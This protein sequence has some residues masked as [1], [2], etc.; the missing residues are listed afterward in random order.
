MADYQPMN[1]VL[2]VAAIRHRLQQFVQ[3][4]TRASLP[5]IVVISIAVLLDKWGWFRGVEFPTLLYVAVAAV[6]GRGLWAAS[7]RVSPVELLMAVD[8]SHGLPDSLSSAWDFMQRSPAERTPQMEAHLEKALPEFGNVR[9]SR[10]LPFTMPAEFPIAVVLAVVLAAVGLVRPPDYP[11]LPPVVV[12]SPPVQVIVDTGRLLEDM[13]NIETLSELARQSD[14]PAI[15]AISEQ[16]EG[17]TDQLLAG[18]ISADDL[19]DELDAIEDDL[20][21]LAVPDE[22]VDLGEVWEEVA[23]E[24]DEVMDDLGIEEGSA[25]RQQADDLAEAIENGDEEAISDALDQLAALLEE[26]E[27][28]PEDA[29]ALADMLE[30]LADVIDPADFDLSAQMAELED[31]IIELEERVQRRGRS[32]DQNR[33]DDA[34]EALDALQERMAEERQNQ[35][36]QGQ[37]QQDLS[38]ALNQAADALREGEQATNDDSDTEEQEADGEN[39]A[40]DA[41]ETTDSGEARQPEEAT[42]DGQESAEPPD[43]GENGSEDQSDSGEQAQNG[44]QPEDI[45]EQPQPDGE[46]TSEGGRSASDALQQAADQLEEMT[47]QDAAREAQER[48][49]EATADIRENLQRSSGGSEENQQSAEDW[50]SFMERAGG[51]QVGSEQGEEGEGTQGS[52]QGEEGQGAGF[53]GEENVGDGQAGFGEEAGGDPLGDETSIETDRTREQ[54]SV[55]Q[56]EDG[57]QDDASVFRDAAAEGFA[58]A[59]YRDVYAEYAEAAEVALET[60]EIP[61]GYARFVQQYFQLIEP[62]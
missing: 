5:A 21:E 3:A 58:S 53:Q 34:R 45:G 52:E 27:L 47:Q 12:A 10:A 41:E 30:R 60:E 48:A 37:A 16:L 20:S 9:I 32:R 2:R 18:T 8:Q 54:A 35:D 28:D 6:L 51:E 46:E 14:D 25:A 19:L 23:E 22:P 56:T 62:R 7:R 24:L 57:A 26:E 59:S 36:E 33:L 38:D 50:N 15:Q 29:E 49:E 13:R 11:E 43:S 40:P 55:E 44:E 1:R 17:L 31:R 39:A 42:N 61:A 4:A